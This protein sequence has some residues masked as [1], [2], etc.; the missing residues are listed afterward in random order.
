MPD[1]QNGLERPVQLGPKRELGP[2]LEPQL[3]RAIISNGW[4]STKLGALR[5]KAEHCRS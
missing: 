5:G 2:S 3:V 4:E 1:A